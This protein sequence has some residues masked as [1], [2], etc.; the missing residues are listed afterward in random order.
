MDIYQVSNP[1]FVSNSLG[2]NGRGIFLLK[3]KAKSRKRKY[4]IKR[5]SIGVTFEDFE[6]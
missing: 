4:E 6:E 1:G 3:E 5:H 2:K